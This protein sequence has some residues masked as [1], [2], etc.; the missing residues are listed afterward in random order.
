MNKLLKM[1]ISLHFVYSIC[2]K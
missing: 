1:K 2:S